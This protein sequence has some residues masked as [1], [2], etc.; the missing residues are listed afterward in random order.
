[1]WIRCQKGKKIHKVFVNFLV[2]LVKIR[3]VGNSEAS[4]LKQQL[5][6]RNAVCLTVDSNQNLC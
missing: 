4:L 3:F 5:H 1:M 2:D 6:A